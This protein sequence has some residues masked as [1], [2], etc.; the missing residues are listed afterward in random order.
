MNNPSLVDMLG[1]KYVSFE[2]GGEY[3]YNHVERRWE[4][5]NPFAFI[6]FGKVASSWQPCRTLLDNEIFKI[7]RPEGTLTLEW[8]GYSLKWEVKPY[9]SNWGKLNLISLPK[10]EKNLSWGED[11]ASGEVTFKLE[12]VRKKTI[13]CDEPCCG[14]CKVHECAP[15]VCG[16]E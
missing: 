4:F 8:N 7:F 11:A 6:A 16:C 5:N 12:R 9:P 2:D 10:F 3:R 15:C 1:A 13:G 14:Y